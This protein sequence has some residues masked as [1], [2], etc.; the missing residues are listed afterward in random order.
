MRHIGIVCEGPTD[1]IILKS[2]INRISGEKNTYVMLQTEDDLT[3]RYGNGWKGVWKWCHDNAPIR[4]K[5]MQDIQPA[6][7]FL[8]IQ[9]DGD[10]SRKE[11]PAHC[12]C[13]TTQCI[14]QGEW[15]P[16]ECDVTPAGQAA[17][18]IVLPCPTHNASVAGFMSHLK[19]LL[20][21]WLIDTT[22][23]CIAIPCDSTEAW[24]VA[25]Y[26]QIPDVE[27]LA[28][29]WEQII[30]RGKFYHNIRIPGQKKRVRIFEQFVPTVCENWDKVTGLCKS[31]KDFENS[32]LTL[33]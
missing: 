22:D 13:K 24:I 21:T 14:H 11:K 4:K 25:A 2:V 23:T 31:A 29:P 7:D 10:V 1:Y 8:V 6:L 5:L 32:L 19:G 3:G 9:M 17:C 30:S 12:W 28:S 20:T 16:L 26:D 33:I 15:N 18:P 27:I